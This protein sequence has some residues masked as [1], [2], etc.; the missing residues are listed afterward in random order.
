MRR[1]DHVSREVLPTVVCLERDREASIMRRPCPTGA[2]VPRRGKN[3]CTVYMCVEIPLLNFKSLDTSFVI[4]YDYHN[5]EHGF[6][7]KLL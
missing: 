7:R 1:A 2:V 5:F 6:G 4:F 3:K